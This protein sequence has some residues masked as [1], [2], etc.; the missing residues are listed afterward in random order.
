MLDCDWSSDVCSS[1]LNKEKFW[2]DLV[3]LL[4][5]PEWAQDPEFATFEARLRNRKRVVEMLNGILATATTGEWLERLS[6]TVPVSPVFDIAQALE[7]PFVAEQGMIVEQDHPGRGKI[8]TIACPVR[9]NGDERPGAVCPGMGANTD[10]ILRSMD[11]GP[12]RI[13]RLREAKVI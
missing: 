10:E 12:D 2:G 8:R 11:Y 7:N 9:V 6:G 5:K 3:K 1:D 13:A 4:G